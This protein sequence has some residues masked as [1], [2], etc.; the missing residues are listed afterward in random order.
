MR[1]PLRWLLQHLAY[2]ALTGGSVLTVAFASRRGWPLI[3]VAAGL[4]ALGMTAII[5]LER[6][7]PYTPTWTAFGEDERTDQWHLLVSERFYDLGG[8]AALGLFSPVS[9]WMRSHGLS[10]WPD[11]APL[12]VQV[13]L[14]ALLTDLSLYWM[15]R[16]AHTVP[17]MWRL[18]AVHHTSPRLHW[19]SVWRSHPLDNILRSMANTGPLALC[20]VPTEVIALAAAFAGMSVLITH[21]NADL[22]T[23][24]FDWIFSTPR[25]HRWHH[26]RHDGAGYTN[27]AP[28]LALWDWVFGTRRVPADRRPP[29]DVGLEPGL[30][31]GSPRYLAQLRAPFES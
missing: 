13:V 11:R 20:G 7:V 21:C 30:P 12:L 24:P 8:L 5:L 14:A 16:L 1:G 2:P 15:H 26:V 6:L 29:E 25:V 27:Y 19:L 10:L 3:P 22:R 18:H 23:G 31:P 9:Q 17:W 4:T 28:A